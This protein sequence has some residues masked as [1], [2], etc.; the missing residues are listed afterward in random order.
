MRLANV[1]PAL[2][3]SSQQYHSALRH[4]VTRYVSKTGRVTCAISR[5]NPSDVNDD[6]NAISAI[7]AVAAALVE[8]IR[9]FRIDRMEP[10]GA[11]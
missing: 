7:V 9:G 3:Q 4:I 6:I 5:A 8:V 1:L 10:Q 11:S 2:Q